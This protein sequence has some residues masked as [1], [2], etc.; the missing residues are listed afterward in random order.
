MSETGNMQ[1]TVWADDRPSAAYRWY[2]LKPLSAFVRSIVLAWTLFGFVWASLLAVG[3]LARDEALLGIVVFIAEPP[4]LIVLALLGVVSAVLYLVW[5]YRASA[6][7][8]VLPGRRD[9]MRPGWAV[10]GYFI[11][12][13]NLVMPYL[14]MRNLTA[15]IR[16]GAGLWWAG[17]LIGE[18]LSRLGDR[19]GE[20]AVTAVGVKWAVGLLLAGWVLQS[21]AGL[22]LFR[23]IAE[24]SLWQRQRRQQQLA[25]EASP[26]TAPPSPPL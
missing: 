6:N 7:L 3:W 19:V 18:G 10:G 20:R 23:M 9:R 25:R 5:I 1:S 8:W 17:L 26:S 11:P 14:G 16:G 15:P 12:L 24:V 13:A 21:L 22:L 2:D 4:A